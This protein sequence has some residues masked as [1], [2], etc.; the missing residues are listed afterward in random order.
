MNPRGGGA[1]G[2]RFCDSV[3]VF[4]SRA[5][6][7]E[8][9]ENCCTLSSTNRISELSYGLVQGIWRERAFSWM[10]ETCKQAERAVFCRAEMLEVRVDQQLLDCDGKLPFLSLL[11]EDEIFWHVLK[12]VGDGLWIRTLAR[13]TMGCECQ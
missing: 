9:R 7:C 4:V 12:I 5:V 1:D 6:S 3:C 13:L 8:G 11:Y 10:V 2:Q